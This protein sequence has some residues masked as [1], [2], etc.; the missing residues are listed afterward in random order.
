MGGE[1]PPSLNTIPLMKKK[2]TEMDLQISV[3]KW[4]KYQ[5]PKVIF[6]S[7]ESGVNKSKASAGM[8]TVLR[9]GSKLPDMF[10]AEPKGI[11]HGLYL[12]FKKKSPYLKD[13]YTLSSDK[14]IQ[15]QSFMLTR[16]EEKLYFAR[17]VWT[18][19]EAKR[20]ID[21]YMRFK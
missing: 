2:Y 7:D 10:I 6:S 21:L 13:N 1:S 9:S 11:Y 8:A 18:F 5:Y 15:A 19:E 14:H 4:L 17:F 16:L 20:L 3:C 12:E